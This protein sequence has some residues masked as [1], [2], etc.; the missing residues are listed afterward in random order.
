MPTRES[1][2]SVCTR[3][4]SRSLRLAGRVHH[5]DSAQLCEPAPHCRH[6]RLVAELALDVDGGGGGGDVGGRGARARAAARGRPRRRRRRARRAQRTRGG[7]RRSGPGG[8]AAR[9]TPPRREVAHLAGRKPDGRPGRGLYAGRAPSDAAIT[10]A[11]RCEA[12]RC[13]TPPS[14]SS[15]NVGSAR[16]LRALIR[17]LASRRAA[18]SRWQLSGRALASP[19]PRSRRRRR[20]RDRAHVTPAQRSTTTRSGSVNW[21][22]FLMAWPTILQTA[23]HTAGAA[24]AADGPP[25]GARG[26]GGGG[27]TPRRSV[28]GATVGATVDAPLDVASRVQLQR[29]VRALEEVLPKA[30]SLRELGNARP[31]L[32]PRIR[33]A[34]R[35]SSRPP[36]SSRNLRAATATTGS[37]TPTR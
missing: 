26:G 5:H 14:P 29:T 13:S 32:A 24:A 2:R 34:R 4:R 9:R 35:A 22:E 27:G 19:L 17:L 25:S 37:S 23:T 11:I 10:K 7:A 1:C 3:G 15:A 33:W 21:G 16:A 31:L 28:G 18:T 36:S 12:T 8:R 30:T 20:S 6:R